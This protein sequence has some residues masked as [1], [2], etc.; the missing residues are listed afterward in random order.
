MTRSPIIYIFILTLS[1]LIKNI[2]PSSALSMAVTSIN[3]LDP[4]KAQIIKNQTI[5]NDQS[6]SDTNDCYYFRDWEAKYPFKHN[7]F[8]YIYYFVL[9]CLDSAFQVIKSSVKFNYDGGNEKQILPE[10]CISPKI[11][12]KETNSPCE[13]G[14]K[15]GRRVLEDIIEMLGRK[16]IFHIDAVSDLEEETIEGL[17][18]DRL[19][20]LVQRIP[21][22]RELISQIINEED[23][24]ENLKPVRIDTQEDGSRM[25]SF[26]FDDGKTAIR[27]IYNSG[28]IETIV[29]YK[30]NGTKKIVTNIDKTIE[31]IRKDNEKNI[32]WIQ[33]IQKDIDDPD[34]EKIQILSKDKKNIGP[35]FSRLKQS[36]GIHKNIEVDENIYFAFSEATDY[37]TETVNEHITNKLKCFMENIIPHRE[38]YLVFVCSN[39][40]KEEIKKELIHK[41]QKLMICGKKVDCSVTEN[42][43][44]IQ[45]KLYA[46]FGTINI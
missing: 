32:M 10:G 13:G 16:L 4:K 25:E 14:K 39:L 20:E 28:I 44:L 36:Q 6:K 15:L 24:K 41:F 1:I 26:V 21:E 5:R 19:D 22:L 12:S 30:G 23:T 40:D 43:L 3:E 34:Y 2:T 7:S 29:D 45:M 17:S 46:G 35:S 9:Q 42:R 38:D 11:E 27:T 31:I 8:R 18:T 37:F 33:T